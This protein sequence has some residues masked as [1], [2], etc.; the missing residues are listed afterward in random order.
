MTPKNKPAKILPY[1][2]QTIDEEDIESVVNALKGDYLT[3]GPITSRFEAAFAEKVQAK[4]AIVVNSGT[5]GLHLAVMALGIDKDAAVIVPSITFL[6]SANCVEYIGAD[7][8]FSDVN[9][10]TG[11]MDLNNI[12]E[13]Y[14]R[15]TGK[16]IKAIILVHLNGQT[17]D[18]ATV[19][20]FAREKGLFIIE[21]ACHA[22]GGKFIDKSDNEQTI[23]N[24]FYSDIAMF[25]GHPVKTIAMGE[26]GILTTNN[27]EYADF[28]RLARSHNMEKRPEKLINQTLA[29]DTDGEV[30][31]WYY[32]MQQPGYNFRCSDIHCA[33]GLSQL[34]KLDEFVKK[35]QELVNLYLDNIQTLAPAIQ[36]IHHTEH[37]K[38]G[39]HLFP[40]LCDFNAIGLSRHAFMK[41]LATHGILTQVHYIPVSEQPYY[42]DKYDCPHLPGAM[43]YYERV[44][45][46]P[47]YP[48]MAYD[49]VHIVI[50]AIKSIIGRH[51]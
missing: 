45:S 13:A 17:T 7:V 5:S 38:F 29:L 37:G 27:D 36:P 2:K 50:K 16:A 22:L 18:L 10:D 32:E 34:K 11:L 41:E 23:G 1:G 12:K 43:L 8:V 33:L 40:V 26:A 4:H 14:D 31:A 19:Q 9:P 46:L 39:W 6:A 35:R 15:H 3:T 25:S 21:D 49:D 30:N 47:L 24:S 44:L 51:T 42:K 28:I 20:D 48:A